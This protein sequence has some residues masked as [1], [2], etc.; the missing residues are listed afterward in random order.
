MNRLAAAAAL[1]LASFALA[2]PAFATPG[3]DHKVLV[4][5]VPPGNPDNPQLIEV[6]VASTA[7]QGHLNHDDDLIEGRD[8][9]ADT[10]RAACT[11]SVTI[12]A[13]PSTS[14]VT[15]PAVTS[16]VT[17]TPDPVTETTTLPATTTTHTQPGALVVATV[18]GPDST[19][20][21]TAAG[22]SRTVIR[23]GKESLAFTGMDFGL[24]GLGVAGL[25]V[26]VAL[27]ATSRRMQG[28]RH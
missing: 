26:G 7:Y 21:T 27:T 24:L 9:D 20:T 25:G 3:P 17:V 15:V 22:V 18:T 1:T 14:T 28:G 4:C 2:A 19:T 13:E 6:D 16:T 11:V 5:H 10:I 8:G 23:D 12:T